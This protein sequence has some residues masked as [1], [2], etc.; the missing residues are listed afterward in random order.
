MKQ[1]PSRVCPIV[2]YVLRRFRLSLAGY[3]PCQEHGRTVEHGFEL[4]VD[5]LVAQNI[6]YRKNEED[7]FE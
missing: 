5:E 4:P 3:T 2:K 6:S 7:L 1:P